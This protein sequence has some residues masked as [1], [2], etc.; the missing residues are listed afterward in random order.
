MAA[1]NDGPAIAVAAAIVGAVRESGLHLEDVTVT[2]PANRSVVR[3]TLDLPEDEVGSLPLERVAEVSRAIS[4]ALDAA[5]VLPQAYQLEVS[6]PGAT[7]PLTEPRHFRRART[8]LVRVEDVDGTHVVGRLVDV[9]GDE[10]VLDDEQGT[11]HRL[12]LARVRRGRVELE[13]RR[14]DEVDLGTDDDEEV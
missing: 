4:D 1:Q 8:R 11:V 3:V 14:I 2:G 5:D 6:S 10:L 13:M 12:P 7:R 9:D